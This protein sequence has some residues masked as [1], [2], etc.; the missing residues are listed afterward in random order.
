MHLVAPRPCRRTA[1]R[2]LAS[3]TPERGAGS[4]DQPGLHGVEE[5]AERV[6]VERQRRERVGVAL[7]GHRG[8]SGRPRG[9]RPARDE[10]LPREE[11]AVGRHVL[12]GHRARAVEHEH[13]VDA[14]ALDLLAHDAPLRP[15]QREHHARR[16]R[17]G[18]A[19]GGRSASARAGRRTTR[20][21]SGRATSRADAVAVAPRSAR[22][23]PA[24]SAAA[25]ADRRASGSAEDH[26]VTPGPRAGRPPTT[27]RRA[28][29]APWPPAAP[30]R[31]ARGTG[32]RR[33][34]LIS[35]FSSRSIRSKMFRSEARVG[36]AEELA[37]GAVGDPSAAGPR[38][39]APRSSPCA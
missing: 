15:R 12:G 3:P 25:R 21:H 39:S 34:S 13:D 7:E 9:A 26:G 31:T 2:P 30:G 6:G 20:P 32:G 14:L 5:Q 37:A 29:A 10:R 23:R 36:G 11:E 38:R 16:R 24:R 8:R 28:R 19:R 18:R 4:G 17:A 33:T 35:D 1:S 22:P 27:A